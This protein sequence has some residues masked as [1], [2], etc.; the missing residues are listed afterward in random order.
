MLV[1]VVVERR[2]SRRSL[3]CSGCVVFANETVW[4]AVCVVS[5]RPMQVWLAS[6]GQTI[7][8][9]EDRSCLDTSRSREGTTGYHVEVEVGMDA[10]VD[11]EKP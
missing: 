6:T 11:R 9:G 3:W 5:V 10:D 7:K 4:D 2:S 8:C 1:P